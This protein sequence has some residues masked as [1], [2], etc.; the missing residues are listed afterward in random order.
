MTYT[1]LGDKFGSAPMLIGC[2]FERFSLRSLVMSSC[3]WRPEMSGISRHISR[4]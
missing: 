2:A 3:T 4:Y 1:S